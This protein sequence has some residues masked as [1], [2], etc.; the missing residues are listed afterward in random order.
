MP[1]TAPH[2]PRRSPDSAAA[3]T[4]IIELPAEDIGP[5]ELAEL[6]RQVSSRKP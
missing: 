4:D 3:D 1:A 2:A 5:E 6:A